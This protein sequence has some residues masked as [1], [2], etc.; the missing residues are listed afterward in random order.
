MGQ[1]NPPQLRPPRRREGCRMQDADAPCA[2]TP[3]EVLPPSASKVFAAGGQQAPYGSEGGGERARG[4]T[5]SST[6]D[7]AG[8]GE[9]R[10]KDIHRVVL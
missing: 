10:R 7:G 5:A 3:R 4:V 1:Q 6:R 8:A 2:E 9:Q